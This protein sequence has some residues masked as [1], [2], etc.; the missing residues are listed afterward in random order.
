MK[1]AAA[2]EFLADDPPH[3]RIGSLHVRQRDNDELRIRGPQIGEC[4]LPASG[5]GTDHLL[6]AYQSDGHG[7]SAGGP[8]EEADKELIRGVSRPLQR[9]ESGRTRDVRG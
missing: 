9:T 7:K 8:D 3:D 2:K 1:R 6:D 5:T 4:D